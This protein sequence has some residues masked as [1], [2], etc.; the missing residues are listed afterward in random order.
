MS[1]I[2]RETRH[3]AF[4][5][6]ASVLL[7][8][9]L[10]TSVLLVNPASTVASSVFNASHPELML[11]RTRTTLATNAE[12]GGT[13][14][15]ASIT[16]FRLNS[17]PR[18]KRT[19]QQHNDSSNSALLI[20]DSQSA[21]AAKVPGNRTWT[22]S[23]L[24]ATGYDVQFLGAGGT[25]FVASNSSGA[26]NY[27]SA[28]SQHQWLLPSTAPALIVLEGGGN[29]ATI[30]ATNAQ[31]LQGVNLPLGPLQ[32][33]YPSSRLMMI[34]TLAGNPS[35]GAARRA[36]VDALLGTYARHHGIAFVSAGNWLAKYDLAGQMAD[37]VHLTQ[38]GHDTLAATLASRLG[39]LHLT[40]QDIAPA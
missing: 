25:G 33:Q 26:L 17:Q 18:T 8:G 5:L 22:Q 21:G 23:A 32:S 13:I 3:A 2:G 29:D 27:P 24:R 7:G 28:L 9:L 12:Q 39:L 30:G 37:R 6:A 16:G 40:E 14:S 36:S 10:A 20:G 35:P 15:A 38:T 1:R 11:H 31:I 34:G 19:G 4:T